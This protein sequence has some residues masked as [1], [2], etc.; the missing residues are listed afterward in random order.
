MAWNWPDALR[1]RPLVIFELLDRAGRGVRGGAEHGVI[2]V[3]AG[4]FQHGVGQGAEVFAQAFHA[5][6]QR[7]HRPC[8]QRLAAGGGGFRGAV[9]D[10][11]GDGLDGVAGAFD[12]VEVGEGDR[13]V[14]GVGVD[15]PGVLGEGVGLHG[16]PP[17]MWKFRCPTSKW[18]GRAQDKVGRPDRRNRRAASA[19]LPRPAHWACGGLLTL[20]GRHRRIFRLPH[21]GTVGG[22]SGGSI[23]ELERVTRHKRLFRCS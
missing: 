21:R 8:V 4:R 20:G 3:G 11:A 13:A 16:L 6:H 12:V 15:Q 14:L 7:R 1:G 18:G 5:T 22:G 19:P 17:T 2:G 23:R 10:Q 9:A